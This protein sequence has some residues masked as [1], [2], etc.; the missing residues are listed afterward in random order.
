MGARAPHTSHPPN[1]PLSDVCVSACAWGSFI[2][3]MACVCVCRVCER[4][5]FCRWSCNAVCHGTHEWNE[6]PD[7]DQTEAV[8]VFERITAHSTAHTHTEIDRSSDSRTVH[9]SPPH[10]QYT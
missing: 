9:T 8:F 7:P 5:S 3:P 1:H 10:T 4:V 6:R 2:N